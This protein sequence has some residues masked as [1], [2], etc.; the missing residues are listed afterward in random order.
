MISDIDIERKE[1]TDVVVA[2][3]GC[4]NVGK[5]TLFNALTGLKQHTGNWTGKTVSTA[6]GEYQYKGRRYILVDLPGIYSLVPQSKE[7]EAA[8]DFIRSCQADCVVVVTDGTSLERT[9]LPLL[10]VMEM[11]DHVIAGVNLMDEA[12]KMNIDIDIPELS[13]ELGIPAV[14]LSAGKDVGLNMLQETIRNL[15]DGFTILHPRKVLPEDGTDLFDWKQGSSDRV[16]RMFANRASEINRSVVSGDEYVRNSSIDRIVLGRFCGPIILLLLLFV[17]FWLTVKGANGPTVFLEILFARLGEFLYSIIDNWPAWISGLLYE[18]IY[19]TVTCVI[20]VMLP[21]LLIFFPLYALLEDLG[22]LPRAAFLMD[23]TFQHCGSCGKQALTMAMGLGCNSVGITG[24][25]IISSERERKIAIITN[26]LIPCNGRLPAMILLIHVFFT[27][28]EFWGTCILL[29]FVLLGVVATFIASRVLGH[30][31]PP[32]DSSFMVLELPRYRAPNIGKILKQTLF[33][34]VLAVLRRAVLVSVPA[35]III[36]LL[37]EISVEGTALLQILTEAL[38]PIG[39]FLGMNGVI[40]MAFL[41]AFPANELL[42]PGIMLILGTTSSV[43]ADPVS[44]KQL[45]I[46]EGWSLQTGLCTMMFMLFHWPCGTT[47]LTIR[48]ETGSTKYLLLSILVPLIIGTLLCG[49]I[50]NI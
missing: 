14:G 48:S 43:G 6:R 15:V 38:D 50:G 30:L 21:P 1:S 20:A 42:I 49:M 47:C 28:Q 22:Y 37:C 11:T 23:H 35:G 12:K 4:P 36:W 3:V 9:I 17:I 8:V 41:L 10:Q 29:L 31:I 32:R 5:S 26:S 40:L 33:D 7:E 19:Q 25:R 44:L 24:T 27:D 46:A 18:G 2:L 45:V 34:Q 16:S 39:T 13:R